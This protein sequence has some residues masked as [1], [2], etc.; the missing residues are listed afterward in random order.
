MLTHKKYVRS[1]CVTQLAKGEIQEKTSNRGAWRERK[2]PRKLGLSKKLFISKLCVMFY[3]LYFR[4]WQKFLCLTNSKVQSPFFDPMTHSI[5]KLKCFHEG[6]MKEY[7]GSTQNLDSISF[8]L[9]FYASLRIKIHPFY[10]CHSLKPVNMLIS[11][12][13][14]HVKTEHFWNSGET[15]GVGA[16]GV[17]ESN[18]NTTENDSVSFFP[19]IRARLPT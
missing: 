16:V 1:H 3:Q 6:K 18:K 11:H 9:L 13:I 14:F 4:N 19:N 15:K 12:T 8:Q 7:W 10:N 2:Q 5:L 17:S